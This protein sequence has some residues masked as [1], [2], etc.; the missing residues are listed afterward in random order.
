MHNSKKQYV[1]HQ[2][3]TNERVSRRTIALLM[4][5]T[6]HGTV[7]AAAKLLYMTGLMQAAT[8]NEAW[9]VLS[10]VYTASYYRKKYSLFLLILM[11]I[12]CMDGAVRVRA[13][14]FL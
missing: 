5:N 14:P 6:A 9:L 13:S 12:L 7:Q 8:T 2:Y 4:M 10:I 1:A 3:N 11:L